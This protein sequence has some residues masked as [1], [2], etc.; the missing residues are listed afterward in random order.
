[1][2]D[3]N[4]KSNPEHS[5]MQS[6]MEVEPGLLIINAYINKLSPNLEK[7]QSEINEVV[8]K[9]KS[10]I[11]DMLN[12]NQ[13]LSNLLNESEVQNMFVSIKYCH[14]QLTELKKKLM[15]LH[16]KT[17]ALERRANLLRVAKQK[18]ALQREHLKESLLI[19]E[20]ELI[21]KQ[22]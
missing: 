13:E 5:S 17:V 14:G 11:S 15:C 10:L 19:R 7:A 3:Q 16:K 2:G 20:Q 21:S 6:K 1:M 22:N 8:D 12:E 4:H 18:E 9:Q